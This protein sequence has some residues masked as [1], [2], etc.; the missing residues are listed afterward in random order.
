MRCNRDRIL[1]N[2]GTSAACALAT[3]VVASL[4]GTTGFAALSPQQLKD[5]LIAS[6]TKID[7]PVWNNRAGNGILNAGATNDALS[8]QTADFAS[9]TAQA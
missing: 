3:D 7:S 6:A 9:P 1:I 2:T 4:R 8:Y 5:L